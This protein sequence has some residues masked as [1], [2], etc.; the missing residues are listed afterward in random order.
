MRK[1][2]PPYC[3]MIKGQDM[4]APVKTVTL[5]GKTYQ[6]AFNNKSARL[7]EDVYNEQYGRDVNY[8]EILKDMA[9]FKHR[10]L[11]AVIYGALIAGGAEMDYETF[12]SAFTYDAIDG[13]RDIIKKGVFDALP[14]AEPGKN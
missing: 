12:E 6:L 1:R 4:A 14:E 9:A 13:L 5:E 3:V 7:A 2:A 8:L 11:L 10:A